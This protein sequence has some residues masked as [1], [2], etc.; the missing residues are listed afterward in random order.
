MFMQVGVSSDIDKSIPNVF[1]TFLDHPKQDIAKCPN[2]KQAYKKIKK[3]RLSLPV[4]RCL[5]VANSLDIFKTTIG[6]CSERVGCKREE[7]MV[8]SRT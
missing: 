3:T 2:K 7:Y 5:F 8:N 4:C 6:K 1:G